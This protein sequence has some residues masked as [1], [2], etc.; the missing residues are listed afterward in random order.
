MESDFVK[1]KYCFIVFV[2][3]EISTLTFFEYFT[4]YNVE[5]LLLVL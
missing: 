2:E 3:L 1:I 5:F 4:V